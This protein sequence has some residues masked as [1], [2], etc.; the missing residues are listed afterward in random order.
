VTGDRSRRTAGARLAVCAGRLV[1]AA[2]LAAVSCARHDAPGR[3]HGPS[4]HHV[5][6]QAVKFDPPDLAVAVGDTVVWDNHDI[7]PHTANALD[8]SWS[9]GS[10]GPDSSWRTVIAGSGAIDYTC[11][12]HPEM[13]GRIT[14][15]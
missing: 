8:G 10:I 3:E 1:V 7:V 4:V 9:S 11:V 13:K 2:S 12:F 15:H 6:M 14:A 5:R